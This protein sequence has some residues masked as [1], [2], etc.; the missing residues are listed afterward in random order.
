[1]IEKSQ[2]A[3]LGLFDAKVPRYTSYP[4]APHFGQDVDAKAFEGWIEAIPAGSAISLYVHV[5]FCR[6]LCWFC[7]CRTQGTQ[8]DS[9]V[10]AYVDV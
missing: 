4:T 5:P 10:V 2:L 9:P 7:A 1:M 6:R 8:T 3:R